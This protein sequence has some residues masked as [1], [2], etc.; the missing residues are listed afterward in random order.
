GREVVEPDLHVVAVRSGQGRAAVD[1]LVVPGGQQLLHRVLDLADAGQGAGGGLER[2]QDGR[3]V[4]DRGRGVDL[5]P[6]VGR[7][8]EPR[9]GA[10]V[11][12]DPQVR[13]AEV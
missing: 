8:L 9:I 5:A 13:V 11:G 3:A 6:L 2:V 10:L 12:R 1:L 4:T 7:Q